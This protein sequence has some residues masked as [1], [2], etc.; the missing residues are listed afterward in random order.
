MVVLHAV[1]D[2]AAMNALE[3]FFSFTMVTFCCFVCLSIGL[4]E[5]ICEAENID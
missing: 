1:K 5:W 2:A 4:F 3:S